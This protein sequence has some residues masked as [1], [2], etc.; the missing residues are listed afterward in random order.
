MQR[1]DGFEGWS[2]SYETA[3][4]RIFRGDPTPEDVHEAAPLARE[5]VHGLIVGAV[6]DE[7]LRRQA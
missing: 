3:W 2:R 1:R 4:D 6:T 5:T 7:T